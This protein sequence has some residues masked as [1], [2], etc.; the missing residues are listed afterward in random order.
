MLRL[1]EEGLSAEQLAIA[2]DVAFQTIYNWQKDPEFQQRLKDAKRHADSVV[3]TS[4]YRRACGYSHPEDKIFQYEGQAVIVPTTK[5]YP[6]DTE[7][8]KFWLTNRQPEEWSNKQRIE[9]PEET[10]INVT[11]K[12]D[13]EQDA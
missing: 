3:V 10:T 8:I 6:P 4:L 12:Q 7:A 13:S 1:A 9:L 2:C 11:I 5:H